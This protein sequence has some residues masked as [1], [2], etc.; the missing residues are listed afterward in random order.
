MRKNLLFGLFATMVLLLT[1]ACQKENDLLGNGEATISF[2]IS[3]PQMATRAFSDGTT[4]KELWYAVYH[5]ENGV[6]KQVREEKSAQLT[7]KKARV[8]AQLA[9]G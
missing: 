1:T 2:E 4:A 7:N 3:T 8:E 6:M 5:E 9:T